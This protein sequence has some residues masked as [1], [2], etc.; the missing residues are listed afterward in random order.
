MVRTSQLDNPKMLN[1]TNS[2]SG[3]CAY[4][5]ALVVM[6]AVCAL[7][8]RVATRYSSYDNTSKSRVNVSDSQDSREHGRQRL[9]RDAAAWTPPLIAPV[10]LQQPAAYVLAAYEGPSTSFL[11]FASNPYY[12]P[13]PI[14]SFLS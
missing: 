7:A 13:P 2:K 3:R 5:C 11:P 8:I 4:W 1:L 9:T 14:S 10:G 6:I 12:R